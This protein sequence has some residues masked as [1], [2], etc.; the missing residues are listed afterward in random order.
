MAQ[1][2]KK[3]IDPATKNR[4]RVIDF[5]G[6]TT[7]RE[8][9]ISGS[10]DYSSLEVLELRKNV[11]LEIGS[12][13]DVDNFHRSISSFSCMKQDIWA[14]GAMF[15]SVLFLP[16]YL[17]PM[18]Q[19]KYTELQYHTVEALT[20]RI[21]FINDKIL[22]LRIRKQMAAKSDEWIMLDLLLKMLSDQENRIS[23][24]DILEHSYFHAPLKYSLIGPIGA[25]S[26]SL[27]FSGLR[28][29]DNFPV[30]VKISIKESFNEKLDWESEVLKYL[31][32]ADKTR[33]FVPRVFDSGKYKNL[34][35]NT[36][37][38]KIADINNLQV[39]VQ[40]IFTV[41][42]MDYF[43]KTDSIPESTFKKLMYD[44]VKAVSFIHDEGVCHGDMYL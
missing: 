43:L 4:V 37:M 3:T 7:E 22:Y 41:D 21:K 31:S 11:A 25:G 39:I 5:G 32:R 33:S 2:F 40:E 16:N 19:Y 28:L 14:L 6:S 1:E 20:E 10:I 18:S 42:L 9:K 29:L 8:K 26:S 44:A 24:H 12:K 34:I 17:N 27:V 35:S 23:A 13:I 36:E 15:I 38:I 30:A